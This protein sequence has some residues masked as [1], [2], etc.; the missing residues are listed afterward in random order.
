MNGIANFQSGYPLTILR[1]GDPLGVG[2]TGVRPE[3]ICNPNLSRGDRTIN[4]YFDTNC[5]TAPADRFGNAGRSTVRGPG[6]QN[7]DLSILKK[8]NIQEGRFVQFRTEFFN[9]FN[10]PNW[11]APGR[12]LGGSGFGTVTSA[13]EPRIIQFGLK[14]VF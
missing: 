11:G 9:A 14:V 1:N 2:T 10:H 13:A 12:N 3:Q 8:F 7:W 5:F 6:S 4:R